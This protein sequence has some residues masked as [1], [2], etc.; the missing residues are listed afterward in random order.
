MS[1]AASTIV[2]VVDATPEVL[3]GALLD[4]DSYPQWQANVLGCTVLERDEQGR[5]SVIQ[6]RV[7]GKV[8]QLNVIIEVV[9]HE[10]GISCKYLRGDVKDYTASY[11][12][13]PQGAQTRVTYS[14]A[15]DPGFP[16]P[17]AIKKLLVTRSTKETLDSLKKRVCA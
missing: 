17:A 12:F 7:D 14:I 3:L 13:E 9:H 15:V 11:L 6:I 2:D 4:F 1:A 8:K 5:G 16:L 10:N